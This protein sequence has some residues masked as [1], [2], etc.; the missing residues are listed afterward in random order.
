MAGAGDEFSVRISHAG[1]RSELGGLTASTTIGTLR[2]TLASSHHIPVH[3]QTNL[4]FKGKN[5][6]KLPETATLGEIGLDRTFKGRLTLIGATEAEIDQFKEEEELTLR[7]EAAKAKARAAEGGSRAGGG[8]QRIVNAAEM[9]AGQFLTLTPLEN[10]PRGAPP[11]SE[12]MALL[13][14]LRYP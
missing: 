3:L 8:R 2:S 14:K 9:G 13:E 10:I 7:R 12:A 6:T 5:L 11:P 1:E 4:I